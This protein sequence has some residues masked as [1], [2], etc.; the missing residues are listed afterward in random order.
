[1]A[2]RWLVDRVNLSTEIVSTDVDP[3]TLAPVVTVIDGWEG[4]ALVRQDTVARQPGEG[5]EYGERTITIWLDETATPKTDMRV[6]IVCCIDK[7][8]EETSGTIVDVDRDTHRAAR[9][10]TVRMDSNR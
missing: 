3:N 2:A 6:T 5:R 8:L 7:T 10:A 9:R 1:M 4:P